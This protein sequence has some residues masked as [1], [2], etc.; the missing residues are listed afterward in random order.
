M[1]QFSEEK[2]N[3]KMQ[4][5]ENIIKKQAEKTL[6]KESW[7]SVRSKIDKFVNKKIST[8]ADLQESVA[9]K[10]IAIDF[11]NIAKIKVETNYPVIKMYNDLINTI[12]FLNK[13]YTK[14]L[15]SKTDEI[16]KSIIEDIVNYLNIHLQT[17]FA[18]QVDFK[19]ALLNKINNSI[20]AGDKI[21][22]YVRYIKFKEDMLDLYNILNDDIEI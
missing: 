21:K 5:K 10:N 14:T 15:S 22:R 4:R 1:K 19:S 6:T 16:N 13:D 9:S 17:F 11:L 2:L 3:Y 12:T 8:I 7:E 18:C 20:K